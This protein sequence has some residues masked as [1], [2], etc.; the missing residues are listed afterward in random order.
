M[1]ILIL[2]VAGMSTRFSQSLGKE[3]L[4]CIYYKDGI[5]ESLLY[6]ILN[7]PV[8]FDKYILVGGYRFQE[9][10]QVIETQLGDFSGS[11]VSVENPQFSSYGSGYSLF[12]GIKEAFKD[13]PDEIMFAEGDLYVD[14]SSYVRVFHSNRSVITFNHEP[15]L[16]DKAVA[17]YFGQEN[18]MH[19]IYDTGHCLLSIKEPFSAIY[20]SGQIWKFNRMDVLEKLFA[21]LPMEAWT[22][23]NLILIENYFR[24]LDESDYELIPFHQWVNCNT[25]SDWEKIQGESE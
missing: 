7:Q 23:T 6:K 2:T 19:Y 20:N 10:Q 8:K 17:F 18:R 12:L 13:K 4:K 5:Q 3:C 14:E 22:G 24:Q 21:T 1:K 16:A 11:I 9:L 25:I 15:I